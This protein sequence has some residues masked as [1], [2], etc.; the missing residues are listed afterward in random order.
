MAYSR[1][2]DDRAMNIVQSI[3]ITV[4]RIFKRDNLQTINLTPY[5]ELDILIYRT[6]SSLYVIIYR[7]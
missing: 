4:Q 7:D 6:L 1:N 3:S 2:H 5:N